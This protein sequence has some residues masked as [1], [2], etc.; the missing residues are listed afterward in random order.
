MK[1]FRE[2]A[3]QFADVDEAD[4]L[5]FSLG[6]GFRNGKA[7]M[8]NGRTLIRGTKKSPVCAKVTIL[9]AGFRTRVGSCRRDLLRY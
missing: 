6:I 3:I 4:V 5:E 8:G 2:T 1:R 9:G 7:P